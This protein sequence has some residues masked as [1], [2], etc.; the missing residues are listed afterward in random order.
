MKR[1]T[2]LLGVVVA[3][4]GVFA[5]MPHASGEGDKEAAP[6]FGVT[7][8]SWIPRLEVDFRGP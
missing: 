8:A 2:Y 7:S 3:L 5:Y 6:I 1:I 4:T